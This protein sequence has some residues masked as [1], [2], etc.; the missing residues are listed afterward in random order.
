MTVWVLEEQTDYE[1][2]N[3]VDVYAREAA[4]EAEADRLNKE[5][6]PRSTTRYVYYEYE[7]IQ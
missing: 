3:V 6:S 7:V 2:G 5:Q 4:A 1:P